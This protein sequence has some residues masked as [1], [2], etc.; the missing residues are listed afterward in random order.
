MAVVM[1]CTHS[2]MNT[3]VQFLPLLFSRYP[4]LQEH[5]KLPGVLTQ[6]CSQ[7]DD[8]IH[9]LISAFGKI[10]SWTTCFYTITILFNVPNQ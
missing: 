2:V 5:W 8:D 10:N 4:G 3:P 9:S 1:I 6:I 7:G